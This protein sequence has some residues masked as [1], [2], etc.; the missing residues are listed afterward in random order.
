MKLVEIAAIG[1]NRE[2]GKENHMIWHLPKDLR[3]F[4]ETTKG[5][6]IVMGRKTFESLP[7]KLP[8]RHHIVLTSRLFDDPSVETFSSISAFL[9]AYQKREDTIFVI[10]GG[11]IYRQMLPYADQLIL[12]EVEASCEE[13]EVYFPKFDPN[14]YES[15]ALSEQIDEGYKTKHVLYTKKKG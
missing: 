6:P 9:E 4:K 8:G 13:A 11:E 12:T 10:G 1:K 2:L 15:K 7:G 14:D 3:F 5:H